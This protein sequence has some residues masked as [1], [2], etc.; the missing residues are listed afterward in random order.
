LNKWLV[1]ITFS[2]L[3]LVPLVAQDA[4]AVT[5]TWDGGGDGSTWE[6]PLNW[7]PDGVPAPN[8][9]VVLDMFNLSVNINSAVTVGPSGSITQSSTTSNNNL[10][11]I[12]PSGSLTIFGTF[13]MND[14]NDDIFMR[15][16]GGTIT[17]QCSGVVTLG[18]GMI[19]VPLFDFTTGP[20][21]LVNHGTI[22]GTQPGGAD[23]VDNNIVINTGGLVQNSGTLPAAILNQG[24]ILQTIPSI[25]NIIGGE[26]IP[27][28][29]TS[30]LLASTQTFSWMIPVIVSGIG[31]GLFVVLRKSENS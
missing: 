3:L 25:C 17:V 22:T 31:I 20:A 30:L 28:E 29:T 18:K 21:T 16:N 13:T 24:G 9:D 11:V 10:R 27:I 8:D 1:A 5:K 26:I 12:G 15:G 19:F 2:V 4:F 14:I 7:N 23:D 6:N